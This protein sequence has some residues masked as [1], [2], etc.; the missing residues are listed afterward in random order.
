MNHLHKYIPGTSSRTLLLLHGTGGNEDSLL[1]LVKFLDENANLLS[2]RGNVLEGNMPRFFKRL[3]EGVFDLEDLRVRTEELAVFIA[4]AAQHYQFDASNV[5]AVGYSN[6]ANIATS[7][8][9]RHP[10]VFCGAILLHGQ[11]PFVPEEIPDLTSTNI[12]ASAG[13]HDP[14]IRQAQFEE[15]VGLLRQANA[16]VVTHVHGG[17]HEIAR[18]E[19]EAAQA[20]FEEF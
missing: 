8:L 1:E 9:L 17:G 16:N 3:S 19:I 11:L 18:S 10:K 12:F 20:W 15:M 7:L 13:Q 4:E 2:P 5:I 14:L 6:G